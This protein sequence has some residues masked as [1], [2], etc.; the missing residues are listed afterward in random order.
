MWK[1]GR[2]GMKYGSQSVE[3]EADKE[4]SLTAALQIKTGSVLVESEPTNATIYLDG[5]EVGITPDTLRSIIPGRYLMEVKMDGYKVWS[6]S[7][8]VRANKENALTVVL[9]TITGS[10]LIE[11][12]PAKA[13]I[14][15]DG[16]EVGTTPESFR[17][18]T[19]G[20]H[21]IEVKMDEYEDWREIVDVEAGK[22]KVLTAL[23]QLRTG[24]ILIESEP[25]KAKVYL[26]GKKVGT[27]AETITGLI[28]G[29]YSVEVWMD[30]Y[31][32]WSESVEVEADTE[33]DLTA[34]LQ[35]KSGSISIN[36]E[37]TKARIFLDG[38][39]VGTT[40]ETITDLTPGKYT[41]KVKLDGYGIWHQVVD[42]E[43]DKETVL[44]AALQ[45]KT[46]SIMIES[47][48]AKAM[49]Y[50]DG[51]EVGITPDTLWHIVPW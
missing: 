49:I 38:K 26:N 15:L 9:Q 36:S 20:P 39:N 10:I 8:I 2:M 1:S 33:K 44:M 13:R 16:D 51:E 5:D 4:K 11:S 23:L 48:P 43:P 42:V 25:T 22:E 6:K 32:V 24:S 46:G 45:L 18:I 27:T 7:I 50:L 21:E 34:V 41:V 14:F 12:E 3:V 40:A 28:P 19:P 37:P 47:K 30:G 35:I 17:Y 31:E 29:K